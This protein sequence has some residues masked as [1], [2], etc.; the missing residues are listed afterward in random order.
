[1][2][3][4]ESLLLSLVQLKVMLPLVSAPA[5][6]RLS[7]ADPLRNVTLCAVVEP[8]F[9]AHVSGDA[10]APIAPSAFAVTA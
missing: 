5:P 7:S 8:M 10:L 4:I 2:L 9:R 3:A 1:M 6:W